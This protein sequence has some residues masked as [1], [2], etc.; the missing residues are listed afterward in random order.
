MLYRS[1]IIFLAL[2]LGVSVMSQA[3]A[4]HQHPI[5]WTVHD[6]DRPAPPVVD[7]GPA[8]AEP[9][10]APSDA[11]VLFD[12]T[13]LSAWESVEGG[14]TEWT[15][16]DGYMVVAPGT[17]SIQT[18]RGFGDAQLHVEWAAPATVEGEGQER[19][20]SGVFLMGTYEVQVLDSYQ[21]ATYPDGQCAAAYGQYPP[22]VNAS[23]PPGEWQTYDI[24][25][26]R[27]HFEEDG[28]LITPARLTVFHNGIL[29]LDNVELTGPTAH[30]DRPPYEAHPARLPLRLQDHGNK[31]RYRNIW[32]RELK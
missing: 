32:L 6:P 28:T 5:Y 10:P 14:D 20:N 11:A 30:K 3:V 31:V 2:I 25:F 26:R 22:L 15:L 27:P 12:G 8:P 16:Q 18:K 9:Q 19:G 17:G 4:Q 23:R 7:P 13:D 24:V 1:L 29:V 21:N